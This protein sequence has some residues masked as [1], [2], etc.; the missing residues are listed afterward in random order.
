MLQ[1]TPILEFLKKKVI[2]RVWSP[3][4]P[5]IASSFYFLLIFL[6]HF[7]FTVDYITTY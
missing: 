7:F 2:F 4:V 6:Q 5:L 3:P 1:K